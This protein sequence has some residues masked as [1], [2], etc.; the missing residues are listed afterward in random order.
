LRTLKILLVS[1]VATLLLAAPAF[2]AQ[3]G[4]FTLD[5]GFLQDTCLDGGGFHITVGGFINPGCE[6]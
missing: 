3:T 5:A 6:F 4:A 1:L 2:A